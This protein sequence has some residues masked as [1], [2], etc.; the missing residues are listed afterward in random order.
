MR[1]GI[2]DPVFRD[3]DGDLMF[4]EEMQNPR[5][6]VT[7]MPGTSFYEALSIDPGAGGGIDMSFRG[8]DELGKEVMS[9]LSSPAAEGLSQVDAIRQLVLQQGSG[10]VG[11]LQELAAIDIVKSLRAAVGQIATTVG[12]TPSTMRTNVRGTYL[13]PLAD[14]TRGLE[15]AAN[16]INSAAFQS[17]VDGIAWIPIVGWI[18]KIVVEV[19]TMVLN[20]AA[21]VREERISDMSYEMAKRFHLPLISADSDLQRE[22]NQALTRQVLVYA[23]DSE[24]WK[25]FMPP[26]LIAG[27]SGKR[28]ETVAARDPD[29]KEYDLGDGKSIQLTEG[30]YMRGVESTSDPD[31][32]A[33]L[34]GAGFQP[35]GSSLYRVMEFNPEYAG[36]APN[37]TGDYA[38]TAR[39]TAAYMWQTVLKGGPAMFAVN[40]RET[41]EHWDNYL[42]GMMEYGERCILKGFTV[43]ESSVR[44]NHQYDNC[45]DME[46][47]YVD[48]YRGD[49]AG[50]KRHFPGGWGH[51]HH[52]SEMLTWLMQQFWGRGPQQNQFPYPT[53]DTSK[54]FAV[55]NYYFH[56]TVYAHALK[57]LRDRQYAMIA[58]YEA[59]SVFPGTKFIDLERGGEEVEIPMGV[60]PAFGRPNH[61]DQQM[62]DRWEDTI[63]LVLQNKELYQNLNWREVPEYQWKGQSV[64]Q[65]L[66]AKQGAGGGLQIAGAY[67]KPVP[68]GPDMFP[69]P[70]PPA[71]AGVDDLGIVLAERPGTRR[72]ESGGIMGKMRGAV[73]GMPTASK[74]MLAAAAAMGGIVGANELYRQMRRRSKLFT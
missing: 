64:R 37:N 14:V 32:M 22:V 49:K 62:I 40:T 30:W 1:V 68:G 47:V 12:F 9:L 57:N 21:R 54:D 16:V 70:N 23:R 39:Q 35:G 59:F 58:G 55:D 11:E 63:R 51:V 13:Q 43:S 7:T 56:N 38:N 17:A 69:P 41:T 2:S 6:F 65:L 52:F 60:Y 24:M 45:T 5:L 25:V 31:K 20:I 72:P 8:V 29:S 74:A 3:K 53:R 26:Y 15:I 28:F 66:K 67:T 36:E 18:I 19:L 46:W 71:L 42:H 33:P 44:S 61:W 34:L 73:G 10:L 4:T 48:E 50:E 27:G